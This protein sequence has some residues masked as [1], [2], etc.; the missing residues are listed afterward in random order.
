[1]EYTQILKTVEAI[2]R[3]AGEILKDY[4]KQAGGYTLKGE[5]DIVTEADSASERVIL[6]ALQQS[7]PDY[8][9]VA[10]E[11]GLYHP[12]RGASDYYWYVDPLDGT[13]NFAHGFPHFGVS[14]ALAGIDRVPVL[15]LIYD[16]LR[17]ECFSSYRGGGAF[18]NGVKLR[19][20]KTKTLIS[21]LVAT[22]FPYDRRTSPDNN[23]KEADA[24][25]MN[26]QNLLRTGS[27]ALDM[28]YVASGRLDGFWEKKLQ[29]WDC[30]AGIV[31][32]EEAGG[33]VTDFKDQPNQVYQKRPQLL[34]TNGLIHE[35]LRKVLH[36]V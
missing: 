26:V 20:S 27:A 28:A 12:G 24:V 15:G 21:A 14:I 16:P 11:G 32:I 17:D 7:Y 30:L 9:I 31:L 22:G 3:Q 10:E 6:A 25:L 13:I 2:A 36:P 19:V 5:I 23:I 1:M 8:G 18:L 29:L 34:A 4:Y 33:K 35:E